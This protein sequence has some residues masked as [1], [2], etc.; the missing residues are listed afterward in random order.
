MPNTIHFNTGRL[1]TRGGQ[2]I[3]ATRH[4]D[5]VVTFMDHSRMIDGEFMFP[6]DRASLLTGD[7]VLRSYDNGA[8]KSTARSR[9]DG[10][11]MD[12]CNAEYEP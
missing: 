12:G 3:T 10:M 11:Q 4:D 1:Y 6:M 2:Q 7:N 8:W 9:T 5:G